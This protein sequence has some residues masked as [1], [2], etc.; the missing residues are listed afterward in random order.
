MEKPAAAVARQVML[1]RGLW[2]TLILA[3]K[4]ETLWGMGWRCFPELMRLLEQYEE[5]LGTP[6]EEAMLE[7]VYQKLPVRNF[8]SHLLQRLPEQVAAIE[9]SGVLWCDWGKPQRI[10]DT[11]Q[12]IGKLPAFP[13]E[14]AAVA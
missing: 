2:N 10:V 12:R 7:A 9:M 13:V 6:K 3:A 14:Y 11:L 1:S 4:V 8:S 5:A